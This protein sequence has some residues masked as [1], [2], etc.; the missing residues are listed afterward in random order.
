MPGAN[1]SG[2]VSGNQVGN[3][4]PSHSNQSG[5]TTNSGALPGLQNAGGAGISN[6][7]SVGANSGAILQGPTGPQNPSSGTHSGGAAGASNVV[8]TGAMANSDPSVGN[9]N[10]GTTSGAQFNNAGGTT[11]SNQGSH[12]APTDAVKPVDKAPWLADYSRQELLIPLNHQDRRF[13]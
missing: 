8:P 1:Q 12:N 7:G 2:N 4:L 11:T 9:S 6:Q 5:M 3:Q 13:F 10:S